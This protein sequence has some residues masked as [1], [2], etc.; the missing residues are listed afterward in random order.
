MA[1]AVGLVWPRL[2]CA[3]GTVSCCQVA[4]A[5]V[6]RMRAE[7]TKAYTMDGLSGLTNMRDTGAVTGDRV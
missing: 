1:N 6:E 5:S 4:P 7:F 2:A 3:A